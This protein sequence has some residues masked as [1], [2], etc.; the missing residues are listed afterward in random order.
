MGK[1]AVLEERCLC[2]HRPFSC[3]FSAKYEVL[4]T[5]LPYYGTNPTD[6]DIFGQKNKWNNL[7]SATIKR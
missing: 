4:P 6:D 1:R 7:A 2:F 3:N 5:I